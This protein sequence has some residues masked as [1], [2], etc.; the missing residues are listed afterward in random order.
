MTLVVTGRITR[1]RVP[2]LC[3]ELERLLA[4]SGRS[5]APAACDLAGVVRPDLSAV[6]AVARLSLTARR[7]GGGPL[8]LCAVPPELRTLLELVGLADVMDLPGFADGP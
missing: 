4:L 2:E 7:A 1:A 6:E 5:A 8:R 3:A